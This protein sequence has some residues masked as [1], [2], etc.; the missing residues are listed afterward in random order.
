MSDRILLVDSDPV[1]VELIT[2]ALNEAGITNPIDVVPDGEAVF[3][4]LYKRKKYS[5]RVGHFPIVIF[6]DLKLPKIDGRQVLKQLKET[7]LLNCIPVVVVTGSKAEQD[8]IAAYAHRANSYIIKPVG[9]HEFFEVMKSAGLYWTV[10]SQ[11]PPVDQCKV[12]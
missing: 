12:L 9:S 11:P 1:E 10:T 8:I 4:Y 2:I 7:D 6:L 3:D 5:D